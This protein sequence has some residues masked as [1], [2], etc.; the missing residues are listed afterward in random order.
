MTYHTEGRSHSFLRD[1]YNGCV[2]KGLTGQGKAAQQRVSTLVVAA[3][4]WMFTQHQPLNT[5]GFID[6]AK[7]RG[8]DLDISALRELYRFRLLAPFFSVNNRAVTSVPQRVGPEP[9]LVGSSMLIEFRYARG[10]GRLSDLAEGPFRSRLRF[11]RTDADPRR[12]W[13]GLI[14]SWYQ[15]LVLLEI[16]EYLWS[17]SDLQEFAGAEGGLTADPSMRTRSSVSLDVADRR[18]MAARS[19]KSNDAV[20]SMPTEVC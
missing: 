14:Y 18:S 5:S 7:C 3:L 17:L 8:V 12:W 10:K 1:E 9:E 6:E 11:Y 15:L 20:G 19:D 2:S 16:R 13:N 4:P